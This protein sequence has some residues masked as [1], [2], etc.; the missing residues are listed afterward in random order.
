[1][2]AVCRFWGLY[3]YLS[4]VC[5]QSMLGTMRF[6]LMMVSILIVSILIFKEY[7]NGL[8]NQHDDQVG[9]EKIDPLKKAGE[10]NRLIQDAASIRRQEL[11]KQTQ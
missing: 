6:V 10:V 9:G 11:E 1:M 3:L 5:F 2:S 8:G 4:N 7:S